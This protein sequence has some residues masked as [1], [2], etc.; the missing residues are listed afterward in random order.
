MN[1]TE[2][3]ELRNRWERGAKRKQAAIVFV[4]LVSGFILALSMFALG[5]AL[6]AA[7]ALTQLLGG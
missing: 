4:E 7:G 5:Y 6:G 3:N 1:E 2:Y